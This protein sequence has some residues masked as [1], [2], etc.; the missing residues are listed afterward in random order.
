MLTAE[1]LAAALQRRRGA[2]LAA[3]RWRGA[4]RFHVDDD[5][6]GLSFRDGVAGPWTYADLDVP[7]VVFSGPA[8]TWASCSRRVRPASERPDAGRGQRAA[9]SAPA[10]SWPTGSTSRRSPG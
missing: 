6:I 8:A 4:L 9:G 2:A 3:R 7:T 10:T 1:R 5:V